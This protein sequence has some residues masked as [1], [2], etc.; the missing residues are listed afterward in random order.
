VTLN[1]YITLYRMDKAKELLSDPKNKIA[2][3]SAKVG[4]SDGNYFGKSFKKT[5][6]M[7]P[8]E[9]RAQVII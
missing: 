9:Y 4:Y 3:I 5:V 7:T 8:G 6:G 1:Q 2:D